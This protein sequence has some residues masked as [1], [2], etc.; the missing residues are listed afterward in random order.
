MNDQIE[1]ISKRVLEEL[2]KESNEYKFGVSVGVSNRHLH[3]SESDKN[4]LFG[5]D[6]KLTVLK[7]LS[8]P[9]QYACN[10]TVTIKT[11]K[12]EIKNVRILGPFRS[13]TQ[14]EI[15]RSDSRKL[16]INPPVR[17]SG[18][19]KNTTPITLIGPKGSIDLPYGCI[20]A[21]RHLHMTE[22]D[23][24]RYSVKNN[25]IVSVKVRGDKAGVMGNVTC[26]VN[27]DYYLELHIDTDDANAFNI[28]NKD[29]LEVER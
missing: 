28:S 21:T 18:D 15:S 17:N 19:L 25:Q 1:L 16:R 23:A 10:E 27:K 9:G 6:T 24:K 26:K 4:K 3:L 12:G 11:E 20:I 14:V 5:T 7:E 8:Q 13:E 2:T 22:E 29:I